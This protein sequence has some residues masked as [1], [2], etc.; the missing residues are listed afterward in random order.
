MK[1]VIAGGGFCGAVVAKSLQKQKG[2]E[3]T[4]IDEGDRFEYYPSL[5]NMITDTT[6]KE[7]ITLP[8]SRFLDDTEIIEKRKGFRICYP[9]VFNLPWPPRYR[10][11]T[12][13]PARVPNR[14]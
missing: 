3:V 8:H 11:R 1:A 10:I 7:K 6:L 2:M 4:V 12:G 14:P 9:V 13:R 5:P